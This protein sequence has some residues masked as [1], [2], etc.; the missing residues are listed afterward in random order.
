MF[1]KTLHFRLDIDCI[2]RRLAVTK[3][4]RRLARETLK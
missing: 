4:V 3:S 2:S 1:Q